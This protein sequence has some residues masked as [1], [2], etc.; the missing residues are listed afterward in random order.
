MY[1]LLPDFLEY[2]PKSDFYLPQV[3]QL[4]VYVAYCKYLDLH[5]KVKKIEL[6]KK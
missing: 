6:F 4:S 3:I 5:V 1:T 2:L